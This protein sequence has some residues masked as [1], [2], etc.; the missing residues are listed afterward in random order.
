MIQNTSSGTAGAANTTTF[1]NLICHNS[2]NG[3]HCLQLTDRSITAYASD[4]SS[5]NSQSDKQI[6]TYTHTKSHTRTH[7]TPSTTQLPWTHHNWRSCI[8]NSHWQ[9]STWRLDRSLLSMSKIDIEKHP[10]YILITNTKTHTNIHA[11]AHRNAH[12]TSA[13]TTS[14]LTDPHLQFT[15]TKSDVT[16]G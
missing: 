12:V 1:S 7:D 10:W 8:C 14:H 4:R 2:Y 11:H 9:S 3:A 13:L 5:F 16:R 15:L 6:Q